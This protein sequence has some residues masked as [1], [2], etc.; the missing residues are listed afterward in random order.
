[1]RVNSENM[2]VV[3]CTRCG[4]EDVIQFYPGESEKKK[5]ARVK[6]FVCSV[7]W[8]AEQSGAAA[9]YN[10]RRG[11][12]PLRGSARQINYAESLRKKYIFKIVNHLEIQGQNGFAKRAERYLGAQQ[13]A[14][15]WIE[16]EYE[17]IEGLIAAKIEEAKC[18][19]SVE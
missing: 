4:G 5:R 16:T 14:K 19:A 9:E 10:R 18:I 6:K 15:W 12:A 8:K 1:M 2:Q 13:D 11:Y 17:K 3:K 7:C